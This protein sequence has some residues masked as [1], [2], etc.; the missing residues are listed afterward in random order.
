M[1]EYKKAKGGEVLTGVSEY[2][3]ED[4]SGDFWF[5]KKKKKKLFNS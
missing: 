1:T 5:K 4:A 3:R 2:L